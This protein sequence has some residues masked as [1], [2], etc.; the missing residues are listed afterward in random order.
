VIDCFLAQTRQFFCYIIA[1]TRLFSTRWWG[2][3][4]CTRPTRLVGF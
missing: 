3:P 1:R 2:G 4:L